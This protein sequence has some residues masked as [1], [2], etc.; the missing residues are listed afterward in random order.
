MRTVI[1]C[2]GR[3]TRA[4]P[5]TV[6]VPKPLLDVGGRPVLSHL[7]GIYASQGFTDF[8]L[9]AGYLAD[10]V[11]EFASGLPA[12]WTVDVVDTGEDTNTGGRVRRV[13][14]LV[15]EEFFL[16]YADGLGNVDLPGL[17]AFHRSHPGAATLTTVPLPSQYGTLHV[18]DT[19][20][21]HGF[22][23]KPRLQD[24]PINAGFFVLD[25]RAFDIWPDPGEDLEREVLPVLGDADELYAFEHR[26]F[27]KSMDTYKDALDLAALCA[28]GPGPWLDEPGRPLE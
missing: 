12:A 11:E 13:A 6:D 24:H 9:A 3:G 23:E 22:L 10:R 26:G 14:D 20:V 28:D 25:Q 5:S 2:G 4:Y 8:V 19:G 18:G 17:L 16:T 7:M 21:V 1:L 27:W 15:G